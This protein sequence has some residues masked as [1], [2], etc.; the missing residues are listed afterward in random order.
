MIRKM[1]WLLVGVFLA[2]QLGG[3]AALLVGAAGGAAGYEAA[4]HGYS[5]QSPIKKTDSSPAQT[6]NQ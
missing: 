1:R 6:Q 2:L 5:V 4:K 3:C